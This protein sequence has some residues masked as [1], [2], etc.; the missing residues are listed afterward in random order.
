MIFCA[1]AWT[2]TAAVGL[3]LLP[4]LSA[5]KKDDKATVDAILNKG[6]INGELSPAAVVTAITAAN[7]AGHSATAT[8]D[9]NGYFLLRNLTP[10]AY[11]V[12]FTAAPGYVTPAPRPTTVEAK[13]TTR[14]GLI[15][16]Y[17]GTGATGG[18]ASCLLDADPFVATRVEGALVAGLLQVTLFRAPMTQD[19]IRLKLENV[20]APGTYPLL[21]GAI[22]EG[23][24]RQEI[25]NYAWSTRGPGNSGTVTLTKYDPTARLVSGTFTFTAHIVPG[26]SVP[27]PEISVTNGTFSDVPF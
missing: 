23:F 6:F 11:N 19:L 3:A 20:T 4:L 9:A 22:S 18:T 25:P 2:R 1:A 5:C 27:N 8:P 21:P 17:P 16:V 12:R 10:G 26:F 13:D 14:L 24:Y 7:N 15:S